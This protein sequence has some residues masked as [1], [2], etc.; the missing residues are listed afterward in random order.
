MRVVDTDVINSRISLNLTS[1]YSRHFLTLTS[2][3]LSPSLLVLESPA[4]PPLPLP[5]LLKSIVSGAG[6]IFWA[7]TMMM[8]MMYPW[9]KTKL[10]GD[11]ISTR[12]LLGNSIATAANYF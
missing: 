3:S 6:R 12:D 8:M 2:W 4:P 11:S 1:Y 7:S 9:A 10:T 5:L